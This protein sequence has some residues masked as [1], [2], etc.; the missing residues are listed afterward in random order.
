VAAPRA[1]GSDRVL[2]VEDD[3]AVRATI[4]DTLEMDGYDVR[5][6]IDG[7]D[8]LRVLEGWRPDAIVLDLMMPR[9]DAWTFRGAQLARPDL[10]DIPVIVVSAVRDLEASAVTIQPAAMIGK[11]FD[12]D[13]LV[14][15]ISRV[16]A[17]R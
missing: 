7:H 10:R 4:V 9:A 12:L 1:A 3:D 16:I 13:V 2:V 8:A 15:T 17:S 14:E 5:V 6:A 11:P